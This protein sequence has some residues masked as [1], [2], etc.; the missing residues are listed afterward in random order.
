[1]CFEYQFEWEEVLVLR[2]VHFYYY[3]Q[4]EN[5]TNLIG[6]QSA[7]KNFTTW[8]FRPCFLL[9][10]M[11]YLQRNLNFLSGTSCPF[12]QVKGIQFPIFNLSGCPN[13]VDK[14][15][16]QNV[17]RAKKSLILQVFER[18]KNSE[19]DSSLIAW[20]IDYRNYKLKWPETHSLY[21][22]F[23]LSLSLCV[24]LTQ[25]GDYVC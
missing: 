25:E 15:W 24:S 19:S 20:M 22:Y 2:V 14:N 16:G 4:V 7:V 21:L 9:T 5:T 17:G 18:K 10:T 23:F 11:W 8:H 12:F 3:H 1:M 6:N 13:F